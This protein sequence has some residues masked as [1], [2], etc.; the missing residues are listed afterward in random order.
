MWESYG[1]GGNDLEEKEVT[2]TNQLDGRL[3]QGCSSPH[4]G[5]RGCKEEGKRTTVTTSGCAGKCRTQWCLAH[6]DV[7]N[8]LCSAGFED[9][10]SLISVQPAASELSRV[11]PAQPYSPERRRVSHAQV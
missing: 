9:R 8:Q 4:D 10:A 1:R 11:I 6:I 3:P 2:Y 7:D 5:F